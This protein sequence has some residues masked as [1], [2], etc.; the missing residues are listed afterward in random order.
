MEKLKLLEPNQSIS[1]FSNFKNIFNTARVICTKNHND[2]DRKN[3]RRK[4]Q[5]IAINNRPQTAESCVK[6]ANND[7]NRCD[8]VKIYA[9]NLCKC[10]RRCV[11]QQRTHHQHVD[12]EKETRNLTDLMIV[13]FFEVV[14]AAGRD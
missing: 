9:W 7:Q 11:N 10:Q 13:A 2:N 1:F 4:L 8:I 12:E 5:S 14:V 3:H 6:H